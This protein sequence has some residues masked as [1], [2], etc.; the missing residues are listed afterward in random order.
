MEALQGSRIT[1]G[2]RTDDGLH[3]YLDDGRLLVFAGE[4]VLYVGI[5]AKGTLQ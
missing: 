2:E 1:G 4:F 5:P 3:I